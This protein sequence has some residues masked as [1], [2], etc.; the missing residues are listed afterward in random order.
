MYAR[1]VHTQTNPDMYEDVVNLFNDSVVPAAQEQPGFVNILLCAD[2]YSG[3]GIAISLW[4]TEAD[5]E[6]SANNGYLQEQL[7]KFGA[8]FTAQPVVESYEVS[9]YA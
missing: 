8:Y 4:E 3:K 9:A 6:D 1:I 5:L 7:A 2:P